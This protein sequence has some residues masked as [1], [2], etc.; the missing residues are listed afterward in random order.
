M[1]V[2][3]VSPFTAPFQTW[4]PSDES[5]EATPR[6]IVAPTHQMVSDGDD[7]GAL[8]APVETRRARLLI[9]F[10]RAVSFTVSPTSVQAV[11]A[12]AA[13]LDSACLFDPS[14]MFLAVL[15]V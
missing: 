15:R 6:P 10:A 3:T 2:L 14:P 4:H 5:R 13:R 8:I 7:S 9:S 11:A 12:A 1:L